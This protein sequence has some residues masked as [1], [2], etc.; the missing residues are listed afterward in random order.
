MAHRRI[1]VHHHTIPPAYADWLRSKGISD[2]GG[3]ELPA[4]SVEE[5]LRLMDEKDI[6][7]AVMF[8]SAPGVDLDPTNPNDPVAR[9]KARE[10]NEAAARVVQDN[11]GRFGFFATLTLPDVAGALAEAAYAFDTLGASGVILIANTHGQ[12]LGA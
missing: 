9:A 12:Y 1:D 2:A 3:R 10:V 8:V 5:T 6:V 4:W 11:P 7:T